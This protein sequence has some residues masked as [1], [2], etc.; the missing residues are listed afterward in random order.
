MRIPKEWI[1][2]FKLHISNIDSTIL[3]LIEGI[4]LVI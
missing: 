2:L 1:F 3:E 4:A